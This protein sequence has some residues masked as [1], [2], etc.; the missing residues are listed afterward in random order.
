MQLILDD[1]KLLYDYT[2]FLKKCGIIEHEYTATAICYQYETNL[3][4]NGFDENTK[5]KFK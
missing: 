1:K 3:E 5:E 2:V 4:L